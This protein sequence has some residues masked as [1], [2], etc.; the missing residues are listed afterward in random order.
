MWRGKRFQPCRYTYPH[1]LELM[2]QERNRRM[3]WHEYHIM[4]HRVRI[5]L[6]GQDPFKSVGDMESYTKKCSS[7]YE[8]P[9]LANRSRSLWMGAVLVFCLHVCWLFAGRLYKR[10]AK[11]WNRRILPISNKRAATRSLSWPWM[12]WKTVHCTPEKQETS[13]RPKVSLHKDEADSGSI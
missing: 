13:I 6:Y 11:L 8:W 9:S 2:V 1:R 5:K 12:A 7:L 4:K 10:W 3:N